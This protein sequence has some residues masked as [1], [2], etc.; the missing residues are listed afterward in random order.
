MSDHTQMVIR[1]FFVI[2]LKVALYVVFV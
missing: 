1:L 2:V